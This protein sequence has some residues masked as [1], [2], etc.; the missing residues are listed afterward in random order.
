[1]VR[2][3]H[4]PHPGRDPRL[5]A[6]FDHMRTAFGTLAEPLTL[7]TADPDLLA[8]AWAALYET[9]IVP[10]QLPRA[11]KE[12]IALAVSQANRCPY[13]VD[14]HGVMLYALGAHG[15]ARAIRR[16]GLPGDA[17]SARFVAWA[18]ASRRR[19]LALAAPPPFSPDQRCEAIGTVLCFHYI[20]RV[21]Q[22]LLRDS[23][24]PPA[25]RFAKELVMRMVVGPFRRALAHPHMPGAALG[26]LGDSFDPPH[27]GWAASRP[28]IHAAFRGLAGAV[29]R[30]GA[31]SLGEQ[32][33]ARLRVHL[34]GWEGE[35]AP[36]GSSW[37]DEGIGTVPED[38]AARLA[39]LAARAPY[40][41]SPAQIGAFRRHH[42]ADADL[43]G[44]LA[45]G[46]F[47]AAARISSW[48]WAHPG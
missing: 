27:L 23:P 25:V 36:F 5:R 9:V 44:V 13:C 35:D 7:H 46:S 31:R 4:P 26:F 8:G 12:S 15:A 21:V 39:L 48:L 3:L 11:T 42:P 34:E 17:E 2:H 22:P 19:E 45:W 43:V 1:M 32:T 38:A 47:A 28:T 24:V 29:E 20:N 16:G 40:R 18:R 41:I 14:A 10:G 37:L 6:L 30:A 33:R